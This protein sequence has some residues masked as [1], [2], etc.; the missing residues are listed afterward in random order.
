LGY[1]AKTCGLWE[2]ETL[3]D[4]DLLQSECLLVFLTGS[5][6]ASEVAAKRAKE[7]KTMAHFI[8]RRKRK[9]NVKKN[10]RRMEMKVCPDLMESLE[11]SQ[12]QVVS[13]S[14][15]LNRGGVRVK[16]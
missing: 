6:R 15:M 16:R 12:V 10:E 14:H 2:E 1:E 3:V 13:E 9:G 7:Y 5:L 11:Q 8:S 4:P